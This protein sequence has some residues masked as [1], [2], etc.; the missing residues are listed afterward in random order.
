M[1]GRYCIRLSPVF[2]GAVSWLMS[3]LMRL[4]GNAA[5]PPGRWPSLDH[6]RDG[7]PH[8][9]PAALLRRVQ[10]ATIEVPPALRNSPPCPG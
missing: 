7:Q 4:A 1:P 3:C 6:L 8:L 10:P 5:R 2:T 9:L